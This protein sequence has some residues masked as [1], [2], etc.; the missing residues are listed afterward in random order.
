[1]SYAIYTTQLEAEALQ[2]RINTALDWPKVGAGVCQRVH[3][4]G[5]T[6]VDHPFCCT[7]SYCAIIRHPVRSEWAVPIDNISRS[8]AGPVTEVA[9]PADWSRL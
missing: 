4:G 8:A 7:F 3:V 5:G 2:A 6:H 1:M 9:L